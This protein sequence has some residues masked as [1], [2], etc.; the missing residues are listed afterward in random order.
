MRW[1]WKH[2]EQIYKAVRAVDTASHPE[3]QGKGI[4]KK[5]TLSLVDQCKTN[6]DHFVFN[7]PN[8]Q[9][10]PGYL[11]MGWEVAG[12]LPIAAA[13]RRPLSVLSNLVMPRPEPNNNASEIEQFLNRPDIESLL[14]SDSKRVKSIST[15]VSGAYLTWRYL[16]VP[17]ARYIAVGEESGNE[18]TGLIIGRI[19]PGRFGHE[20]R[21]TDSFFKNDAARKDL[22]RRLASKAS[23]L[24]VD[25][26]TSSGIAQRGKNY[27]HG[28]RITGALGPIVTIRSLSLDD[29]HKL[30]EFREWSPSIGDLEL[31]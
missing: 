9:S 2:N 26:I 28:I 13:I 4:F 23:Q 15:N 14:E 3:H 1:E 11:K 25:Y 7:T 8:K 30:K 20:L 24:K 31:F 27:L 10:K 6:G 19:K 29:L 22:M 16:R 18:L 12:K 5:L 17:V 21:L